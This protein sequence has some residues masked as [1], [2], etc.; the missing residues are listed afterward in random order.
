MSAEKIEDLENRTTRL[1]TILEGVGRAVEKQTASTEKLTAS[2]TEMTAKFS[3]F[4]DHNKELKLRVD[5]IDA[6]S[7]N[8]ETEIKIIKNGNKWQGWAGQALTIAIVG[9]LFS[10]ILLYGK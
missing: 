8:N 5:D 9:A 2:V 10:V 4:I 7:K 1:E 6:R 3:V